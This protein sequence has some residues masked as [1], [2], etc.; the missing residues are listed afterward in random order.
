MPN[1]SS[2]IGV[3]ISFMI[4]GCQPRHQPVDIQIRKQDSIVVSLLTLIDASRHRGIPVAFYLPHSGIERKTIPVIFSHGYG[5]NKGGDYL[6]YSYLAT[7]LAKHGYVVVSIQHEIV[8]DSLIPA[9]GIPQIVR[10]SNWE[11]GVRNIG[12]VLEEMRIRYPNLNY[13]QLVLIGH[14]NGG[15]MAML[16]GQLHP[17]KAAKII[18]LDNRRVA[19]PRSS[20]PQIFSLRSNDQLADEGVLPSLREQHTFGI[21]IVKLPNTGHNEMDDHAPPEKQIE[22]NN[23]LLEFL[24]N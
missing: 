21:T 24:R 22:I 9:T 12:F 20:H 15:D 18:S 5:E 14:S 2:I 19:L 1:C 4:A 3:L 6:A 23:Y 17:E 16:F 13:K 10:R 11:R 8:T 7:N